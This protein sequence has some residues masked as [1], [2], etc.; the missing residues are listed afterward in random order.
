MEAGQLVDDDVVDVSLGANAFEH[1]LEARATGGLGAGQ[2][3]V[4]VLP[5]DLEP[6]LLDLL[7]ARQTLRG[8]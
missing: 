8:Q 1:L 2:P 7:V 3:R 4:D 5:H 6:H